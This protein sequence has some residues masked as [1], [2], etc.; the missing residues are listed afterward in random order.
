M[1]WEYRMM[2]VETGGMVVPN[3]DRLTHEDINGLGEEGWE[4]VA[5]VPMLKG[6][7]R[8]EAMYFCFERLV[9]APHSEEPSDRLVGGHGA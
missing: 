7:G 6:S 5:A 4:M 1:G 3:L 8:T 9:G 2:R